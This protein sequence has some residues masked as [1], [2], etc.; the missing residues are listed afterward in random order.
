MKIPKILS[1][2]LLLFTAWQAPGQTFDCS[3][4]RFSDTIFS[5]LEIQT[6]QFG[7]N[8]TA[9]GQ[10]QPLMADVYMPVGDQATNR[11]LII[12]AF[13]GSFISGQ[14]ADM[15]PLAQRY[16]KKGHVVASIDYRLYPV[17]VLG[18]PDD[19]AIAE[20]ILGAVHD[21]RAAVR[22][23]KASADQN[24]PYGIDPGRIY[25]GGIS[26]GSITAIQA[27]YLDDRDSLNAFMQSYLDAHGGQEGDSS[28]DSL[29]LNYNS[30]V[31]GVINLSGAILDTNF[32]QAGDPPIFSIQ[33]VDDDVV[34]FQTGKAAGLLTVYGSGI[35]HRVTDRLGIFNILEAV[36]G[37]THTDIYF[38][39]QFAAQ[40]NSYMDQVDHYFVEKWCT[41][42]TAVATVEPRLRVEVFPNPV[43]NEF[44]VRSDEPV[45][46]VR[47]MNPEG[48]MVPLEG[49]GNRYRLD[50]KLPAGVYL[51]QMQVGQRW[52]NRKVVKV[53]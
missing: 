35:I 9:S 1:L 41:D 27:A 42:L 16:A 50:V 29:D 51:L 12:L 32:I 19:Q 48:R 39:P 8:T 33:G 38:E 36:P 14:R 44:T 43:R 45:R 24:N 7:Q 15:A 22:F 26:A 28:L 47:L 23:F 40:L 3:Q 53:Y 37:G 2:L 17:F 20:T 52:I 5:E 11:P 49:N 21:M 46:Q 4:G 25:V 31:Q 6:V 13:G 10:Q 30:Q 34:P 18:F